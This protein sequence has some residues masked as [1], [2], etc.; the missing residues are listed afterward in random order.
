M[1]W[2]D[3]CDVYLAPNSVSPDGTCPACQ[4]TVDTADK[5]TEG[6]TKVPW[7]FWFMVVAL[8][9][10]LGWRLVEGVMWAIGHI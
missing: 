5:V 3:K 2:C 4:S 8:V 7:H 9:G 6:A 1:P 10:Y